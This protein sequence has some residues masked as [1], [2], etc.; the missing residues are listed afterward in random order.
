MGGTFWVWGIPQAVQS[1][2]KLRA[3]V[4]PV[5]GCRKRIIFQGRQLKRR[6]SCVRPFIAENKRGCNKSIFPCTQTEEYYVRTD[7]QM[8]YLQD[9]TT[10]ITSFVNLPIQQR[11]QGPHSRPRY[12][13]PCPGNLH[14]LEIFLILSNLQYSSLHICSKAILNISR[15][16]QVYFIHGK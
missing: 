5:G 6:F 3:L 10:R 14:I 8:V 2:E 11:P 1:S 12:S 16:Y 15:S 4:V 9:H 7:V 13:L